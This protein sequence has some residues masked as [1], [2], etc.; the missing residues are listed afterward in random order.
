MKERIPNPEDL[1]FTIRPE[2]K[3]LDA[4]HIATIGQAL[5]ARFYQGEADLD[6]RNIL[7]EPTRT[8]IEKKI[9][10]VIDAM[11]LRGFRITPPIN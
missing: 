6:Y 2:G 4:D 9:K 7:M 8:A 5:Y 11:V 3:M 10:Q 1:V